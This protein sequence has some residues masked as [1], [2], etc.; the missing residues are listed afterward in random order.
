MKTCTKCDES[1]PYA[2]FYKDKTT[3]DGYHPWCKAHKRKS[4]EPPVKAAYDREYRVKNWLRKKANM[5]NL[6]EEQLRTMFDESKGLCAICGNPETELHPVTKGPM[7]LSI[8][9]DHNTNQ[10]RGL[11][12]SKHNK[13]I[14][15]F[16]DDANLLASAI[17]YL[18]KGG[19]WVG[20]L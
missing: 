13:A 7:M 1:K 14:G 16:N 3:K 17:S 12:C 2:E 4:A 11:L 10:V 19:R 18:K 15:M 20:S 8:D 6:S 9:H 5:Y